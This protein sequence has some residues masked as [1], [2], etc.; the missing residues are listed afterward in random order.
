MIEFGEEKL[1][2]RMSSAVLPWHVL[3]FEITKEEVYLGIDPD[4]EASVIIPVSD[5]EQES[6]KYQ[7]LENEYSSSD[8]TKIFISVNDA[9]Y[10]LFH[11][12]LP[13]VKKMFEY[14]PS[15][16]FIIRNPWRRYG[17]DEVTETSRTRTIEYALRFFDFLGAKYSYHG[18]GDGCVALK[19]NNRLVIEKNTDNF[20]LT[21]GDIAE[22]FDAM[23]DMV[24]TTKEK[25]V[26]PHRKVYLTRTHLVKDRSEV[27]EVR[28]GGRNRYNTDLRIENEKVLE[29]YFKSNGYEIVIPEKKFKTVE[30]QIRFFNEVEVLVGVTGSGL[31]NMYF[32]QKDQ[33]VID[34]AA[35]LM[36]GDDLFGALQVVNSELYVTDAYM[37]RQTY[38]ALPSRRDALEVIPR[39]EHLRDKL[40]L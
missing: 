26:K 8:C 5:W 28:H 23:R 36:F 18:P 15:I 31:G 40:N 7:L 11:D 35:E 37:K 39:F 4:R 16:Y 6:S 1:D 19:V 13:F 9:F 24:L 29:D 33:Y 20:R 17:N 30:D 10:T 32:M 38:I 2:V 14:D 34:I 3:D 21:A 22:T 12:L 25:K 27:W